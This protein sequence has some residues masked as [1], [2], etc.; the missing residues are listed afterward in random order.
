MLERS[1][2]PLFSPNSVSSLG[3]LALTLR[4]LRRLPDR[5]AG[6]RNRETRGVSQRTIVEPFQLALFS[7]L[8]H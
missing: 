2:I 3:E 6:G 1:V 5:S 7:H 4:R 8:Q